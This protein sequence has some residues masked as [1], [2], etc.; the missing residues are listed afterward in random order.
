MAQHL[1][2]YRVPALCEA[3]QVNRSGVWLPAARS[4][5]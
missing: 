3:L 1:S 2:S 5:V 4:S